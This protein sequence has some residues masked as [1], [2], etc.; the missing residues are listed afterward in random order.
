MEFMSDSD[1]ES[2]DKQ[3]PLPDVTA[4]DIKKYNSEVKG[5]EL[6]IQNVLHGKKKYYCF[7]NSSVRV[8]DLFDIITGDCLFD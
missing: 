7:S 4:Q 5:F 1:S 3:T 8:R 2:E 6:V